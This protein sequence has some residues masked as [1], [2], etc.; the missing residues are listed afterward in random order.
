MSAYPANAGPAALKSQYLG[1]SQAVFTLGFAIGPAIGVFTW[2]LIHTKVWW[3][4]GAASLVGLV[5]AW[6]GM[7]PAGYSEEV[8]AALSHGDTAAT[9]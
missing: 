4:Y 8:Q 7:R 3:L 5:L 6:Y 9:A 2:D 1:T